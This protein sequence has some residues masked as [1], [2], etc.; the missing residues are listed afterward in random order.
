MNT[1]L[2]NCISSIPVE[3]NASIYL[4]VF[5]QDCKFNCFLMLF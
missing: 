5:S 4:D 3:V 1:A 2:D